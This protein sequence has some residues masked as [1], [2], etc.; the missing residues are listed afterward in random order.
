MRSIY[1]K[2]SDPIGLAVLDVVDYHGDG[3]IIT[4]INVPKAHRGKGIGTQL[5]TECLA[6]ADKLGV[7]LWLEIQSS[8]GPSYEELE[9][10]YM[11]HGFKGNMIYR[12]KP[13]A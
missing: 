10:W 11:R 9:A 8:D 12:R 1:Q 2:L 4:R 6:E 5:L 3:Y 13:K 7:K